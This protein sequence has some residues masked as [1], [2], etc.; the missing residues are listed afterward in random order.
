MEACSLG[1][2][3]HAA[4]MIKTIGLKRCSYPFDWIF[5]NPAIIV[6]C[7]ENDFQVFLDRSLHCPSSLEEPCSGHMIY[8]GETFRHRNVLQDDDYAYYVRCV[9]RFR[10][11]LQNDCSKFF[12]MIMVNRGQPEPLPQE[13]RDILHLND[14]LSQKTRNHH[15]IVIHH[16]VDPSGAFQ[17]SIRKTKDVTMVLLRTISASDGICL[18]DH[19]ENERLNQ[20]I[21]DLYNEHITMSSQRCICLDTLSV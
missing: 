8:G 20:I 10:S 7:L 2:L 21:L 17:H 12:I 11:L 13:E 16:H 18:Q 4:Y 9:D 15:L 3:C 14:A 1:T 19:A 6:D 5:S